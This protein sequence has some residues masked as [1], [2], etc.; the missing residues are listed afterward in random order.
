MENQ[1]ATNAVDVV[2]R[3]V[4][5]FKTQDVDAVMR[6]YADNAVLITPEH[7]FRGKEEVRAFVQGAMTQFP[8]ELFQS[9]TVTR[10]DSE[11]EVVYGLWHANPIIKVAADT[12]VIRDGKI[13]VQTFLFVQ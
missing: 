1:V 12:Y 5:A 11:G 6:D 3:H 2:L 4:D 10:M 7:T 13:A 9:I 8:P